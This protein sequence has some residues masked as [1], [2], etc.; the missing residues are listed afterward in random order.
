MFPDAAEPRPRCSGVL[1]LIQ[2]GAGGVYSCAAGEEDTADATVG[3][4]RG[5]TSSSPFPITMSGTM[6]GLRLGPAATLT[7]CSVLQGKRRGGRGCGSAYRAPRLMQSLTVRMHPLTCADDAA[8]ALVLIF[9]KV[10]A[11]CAVWRP[12]VMRPPSGA[13]AALSQ[14]QHG[15]PQVAAL[16]TYMC[17]HRAMRTD[18]AKGADIGAVTGVRWG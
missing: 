12:Q 8:A 18:R 10:A 2:Q 14:R 17:Q 6:T 15:C 3:E 9:A 5:P 13:G 1:P 16:C 7:S 4:G 11:Q